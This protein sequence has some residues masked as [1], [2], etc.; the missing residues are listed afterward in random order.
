MATR[1]DYES[2]KASETL[3]GIETTQLAIASDLPTG[4]KASETLLGIET[5]KIPPN[6]LILLKLQSL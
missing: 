3:L 4:F 2:F 6:S 5:L 1:K